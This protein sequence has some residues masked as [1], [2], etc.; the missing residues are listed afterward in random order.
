M[1]YSLLLCLLLLVCTASATSHGEGESSSH[2]EGE[3]SSN[4]CTV[5]DTSY[6]IS[7][8]NSTEGY[9]L[10]RAIINCL[11]YSDNRSTLSFGSISYESMT[12]TNGRYTVQCNSGLLLLSVSV[13]GFREERSSCYECVDAEDPCEPGTDCPQYCDHCL[14]NSECLLCTYARYNGQCLPNANCPNNG[15]PNPMNGNECECPHNFGGSNCRDCLLNVTDCQNGYLLNQAS[16]RCEACPSG[17]YQFLVDPESRVP[18]SVVGSPGEEEGHHEK[19]RATES[20]DSHGTSETDT[21]RTFCVQN[22][23][24]GW[25]PDPKGVCYAC[26]MSYCLNC[27]GI[28]HCTRCRD[29]TLVY[30]DHCIGFYEYV[31]E[32]NLELE[33]EEEREKQKFKTE[34]L[35]LQIALPL[36]CFFVIAAF[37][38]I[39]VFAHFRY[40]HVGKDKRHRDPSKRADNYEDTIES[41]FRPQSTVRYR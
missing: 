32:L 6:L 33:E 23:L 15:T 17:Y 28:G 40:P 9:N 41:K 12:G 11:E 29:G 21:D 7:A 5:S 10:T 20:E 18:E 26:G 39:A 3:S 14:P 34:Q 38:L 35:E 22:C 27:S 36:V 4:G 13:F 8:I 25:T 30:K 31:E 2:G 19:K 1:A 24:Y 16:C 37:V